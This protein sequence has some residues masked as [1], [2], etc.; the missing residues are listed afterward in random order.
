MSD[1]VQDVVSAICAWV[2]M[3]NSNIVASTPKGQMPSCGWAIL[4]YVEGGVVVMRRADGRRFE[5][6]VSER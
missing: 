6:K 2:D 5:I 3:A 4:E 1:G